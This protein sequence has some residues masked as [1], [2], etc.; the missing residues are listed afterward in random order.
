MTNVN[1]STQV[2]IPSDL[3]ALR[4]PE[5]QRIAS[6]LGITGLSKLRKGDL[7]A[8]IEDKRPATDIRYDGKNR[9]TS[10]TLPAPDGVSSASRPQKTYTY[11]EEDA[12]R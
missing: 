9:A 1:D 5:L 6:S 8:S 10:V 2:E 7:I 3:R 11:G 12:A 4:L